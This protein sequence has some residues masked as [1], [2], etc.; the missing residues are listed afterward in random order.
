SNP[1]RRTLSASPSTI[2]CDRDSGLAPH[3]G[4]ATRATNG[5]PGPGHGIRHGDTQSPPRSPIGP[6]TAPDGEG[7]GTDR[8]RARGGR[9]RKGRKTTMSTVRLEQRSRRAVEIELQ[10]ASQDNWD[11]KHQIGRG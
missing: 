3:L 1:P 7:V 2:S 4:G 5:P 9:T 6:I 11:N 10:P 8:R